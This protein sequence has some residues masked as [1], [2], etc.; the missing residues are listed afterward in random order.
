MHSCTGE[1]FDVIVGEV[2]RPSTAFR[3][4]DPDLAGYLTF[5]FSAFDWHEESE[6]IVAHPRDPFKRVDIL[7]A[8]GR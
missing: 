4:D 1:M 2:R 5:D 7:A 6:P 3:P 8:P